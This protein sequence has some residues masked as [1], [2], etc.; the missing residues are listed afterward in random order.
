VRFQSSRLNPDLK[1]EIQLMTTTDAQ[2]INPAKNM[3]SSAY[4]AQSI[5]RWIIIPGRSAAPAA[6]C[7][8]V[9]TWLLLLE[10]ATPLGLQIPQ[11]T[12]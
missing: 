4:V 6:I 9:S 11:K 10:E 5:S 3:H 7:N 12:A 2:P 1:I 8:L